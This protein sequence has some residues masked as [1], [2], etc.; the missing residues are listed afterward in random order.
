MLLCN[1]SCAGTYSGGSGTSQSPY[2]I[3]KAVDLME[4]GNTKSDFNASFIM[5]ADIDMSAWSGTKFKFI[6]SPQTPFTGSFNGNN[7]TISNLSYATSDSVDYAGLFGVTHDATIRNL[8]LEDVDISVGGC[9][10][11]SLV[12]YFSEGTIDNCYAT[13]ELSASSS[14]YSCVGGLVGRLA[15][16]VSNSYS[17]VSVM[18][19]TSATSGHAYAGGLAGSQSGG[20]LLKCFNEGSVQAKAT[21]YTPSNVWV[22]AGGIAG[23]HSDGEIT[24]C[25]NIGQIT[26]YSS[27]SQNIHSVSNSGGLV[28]YNDGGTIIGCYNA[29]KI[30]I[31]YYVTHSGGLFGTRSSGKVN[32]C[33][34]DKQTSGMTASSG[35]GATSGTTGL[36]SSKMLLQKTYTSAKWDF[37][38]ADGDA[39]DWKIREGVNY[40]KLI[41]EPELPPTAPTGLTLV[42]KATSKAV[43]KW[44]DKSDNETGFIV[45]RQNGNYGNWQQVATLAANTVSYQDTGLWPAVEYN[46]RVCAYNSGGNSA[47]T[48]TLAVETVNGYIINLDKTTQSFASAGGT[49]NIVISSNI[50]WRAVSKADWVTISSGASGN[51]NGTIA[52]SVTKNTGKNA[53]VGTIAISGGSINTVMTVK[54]DAAPSIKSITF[55]ADKNRSDPLDSFSITGNFNFQTEDMPDNGLMTV[56]LIAQDSS[57]ILFEDQ[58]DSGFDPAKSR[59]FVYKKNSSRNGDVNYFSYDFSKKTFTIMATG[60]D[61][62]GWKT[63]LWF[64]VQMGQAV[65]S[66]IIFGYYDEKYANDAD[67]QYDC[68]ANSGLPIQYLIGQED[69]LQITK[70][71]VKTNN[72][73]KI[74]AGTISGQITS[75]AASSQIT[76]AVVSWSG[77]SQTITLTRRNAGTNVL[78][79]SKT[80][81]QD[82]PIQSVSFDLDKCTFS[83]NISG[84][85]VGNTPLFDIYL[86]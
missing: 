74:T 65:N 53:R 73:T 82:S 35:A 57:E 14:T 33:F 5:T 70:N 41:W 71:T 48:A 45:E 84:Q 29:G 66:M 19:I 3:A 26:A 36:N 38:T 16:T 52:F 18:A 72:K 12:G 10:V 51:G 78:T 23:E 6:G 21:A 59:S 56:R 11:G 69:F 20:K 17:D 46:Y 27:S 85:N 60:Q 80:Q 77:F 81:P 55:K 8:T 43:I 44:T 9:N 42:S 83:V 67:S 49:G 50:S 24:S 75:Q 37:V 76:T 4:L 1:V 58:F 30:N 34:W 86:R 79:Y 13:G 2:I 22:A 54:Q 7:H 68:K 47:Y 28:G 25:Y 32:S 31:A 64:E 62:S 61:L 15:G 40:P 39:A 63:P